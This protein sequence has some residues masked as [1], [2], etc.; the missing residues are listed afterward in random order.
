MKRTLSLL[1]LLALV[2]SLAACGAKETPAPAEEDGQN[3]VMNFI[4]RYQCDR[5]SVFV[6]AEGS[7]NAKFTFSWGSSAW[8]NSEWTMSGKFDEAT[9]TV[10]YADGRRADLTY[11]D[12]G[13]LAKEDVI[14]ENGTGRVV[15][16]EGEA[17]SLTWEDDKEHAADGMVFTWL[18]VEDWPEIDSMANP[19]HEATEAEALEACANLFQIPSDAADVEWYVMDAIA[20][21]SPLTEAR[22]TLGDGHSCC[23]RAQQDPPAGEDADISGMYYEWKAENTDLENWNVPAKVYRTQDGEMT[24]DLCTWYDAER[25]TAYSLSV[26]A[27]DLDGFDIRAVAEAMYREQ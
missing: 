27:A 12:D 5:C 14:Y 21:V 25:G 20:D 18:P 17:L 15:F 24:V 6:E 2:L 26:I 11:G 10:E 3:P 16:S 19:W 22:F 1:A 13:K 8:E 7:E 23:T 9:L 4:G